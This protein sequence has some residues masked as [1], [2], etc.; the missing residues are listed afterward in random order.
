MGG[1]PGGNQTGTTG[2]G[3]LGVGGSGGNGGGGGGGYWGGA[4]AT[5]GAAGGGG[6]SGFGPTGVAFTTGYRAGNGQVVIT[7][8][9][10]AASPDP[11][12]TSVS[13]SPGAV[14][15]GQSTSCMATV[16]DTAASNQ[17]TP[18]GTVT[19]S[20]DTSGGSFSSSGSCSPTGTG[21]TA[22][23]S[24]TYAPGQ[25]GSG[26]HTIQADYGG[27]S[28]HVA[29][30]GTTTVGVTRRA[31]STIVSCT[32]VSSGVQCTATVTDTD[33]VPT[34]PTGTVSFASSGNGRFSPNSCTL[35]TVSG[36]SA[37]CTVSFAPHPPRKGP[38]QM[39]TASYGGDTTHSA[40]SG[41]TVL[42]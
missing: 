11:T 7:Y 10:S 26:T 18:G 1:A 29:S 9:V 3:V 40:S 2:S 38:G 22:S 24:V 30:T 25:I 32:P 36:A 20:S 33:A 4:S 14:D 23:C 15:V 21:A 35:S 6:G 8:T 5:M 34:A 16:T 12:S 27:E 41:M 13:C 17:S 37:S 31:T 39:I 42:N 28:T 19:F